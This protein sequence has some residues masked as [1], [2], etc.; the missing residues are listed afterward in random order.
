M[1]TPIPPN[2]KLEGPFVGRN[3]QRLRIEAG[4]PK[5]RSPSGWALI[6]PMSAGWSW[7]SEI[8]QS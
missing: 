2:I 4:Y 8:Q 1:S 5:Q 7:G 6:A 3:V